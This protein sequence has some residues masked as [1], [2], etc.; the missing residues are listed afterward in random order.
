MSSYGKTQ[1]FPN[2]W[3]LLYK[4]REQDLKQTIVQ[5]EGNLNIFEIDE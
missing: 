4:Y 2:F 5:I 1:E 3:R